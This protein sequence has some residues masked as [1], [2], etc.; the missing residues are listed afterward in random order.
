MNNS[1]LHFLLITKKKRRIIR[2]TEQNRTALRFRSHK[3]N[4][5]ILLL[6]ATYPNLTSPHPLHF[7]DFGATQRWPIQ[8]MPYD[9]VM[10]WRSIVKNFCSTRSW[11]P[12]FDPVGLFTSSL[13]FCL[14]F[15][16][17]F[18]FHLFRKVSVLGFVQPLIYLIR[19]SFFR[20]FYFVISL[21]VWPRRY[22]FLVILHVFLEIRVRL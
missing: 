4:H 2:H 13:I 21:R 18:N 8:K 22:V 1:V 7:S 19:F 3:V 14:G 11:S 6:S 15:Q 20:K 9:A 17:T 12:G 10:L 5:S 16:F